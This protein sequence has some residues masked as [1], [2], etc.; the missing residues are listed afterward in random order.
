MFIYFERERDRERESSNGEGQRERGR[1]RKNPKQAPVLWAQSQTWGS[2]PRCEIIT[3]ERIK[4]RTL[5]QW[6]HPGAFLLC[7]S[8]NDLCMHKFCVWNS[9]SSWEPNGAVGCPERVEVF[10]KSLERPALNYK[11]VAAEP[12]FLLREGCVGEGS[13]LQRILLLL[14]KLCWFVQIM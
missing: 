10:P 6:S 12:P 4:G 7:P 11:K 8:R 2:N 13:N 3:W 1:E 5:N 14:E 9:V